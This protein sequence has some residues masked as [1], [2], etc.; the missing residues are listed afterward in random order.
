MGAVK[1]SVACVSLLYA[2]YR[3]WRLVS[4]KS[5]HATSSVQVPDRAFAKRV[6]WITGASSGIGEALALKLA[7]LGAQLVLTARSEEGLDRVAARVVAEGGLAPMVMTASLDLL[8]AH[9]T[10]VQRII[11]RFGALD[12]VILNHGIGYNVP[13]DDIDMDL[14]Q[15][16]FN[17]NVVSKISLAKAC[18]PH[19]RKSK[20]CT[21][22]GRALLAVTASASAYLPSP[23]ASVY[24]ATKHAVKGFFETI[25]VEVHRDIDIVIVAP[26][27]VKSGFQTRHAQY[28]G[29]RPT[30]IEKYR[31]YL[32]VEQVAEM[33]AG[34]VYGG[35]LYVWL[36]THP[37][38]LY[39]YL[40]VYL[41]DLFSWLVPSFSKKNLARNLELYY[42]N[43]NN[44]KN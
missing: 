5:D 14:V 39:I 16:V 29:V 41:P 17:V 7:R 6:L 21:R 12:G 31:S 33:Y 40:R 26:G 9:A 25:R 1:A 35:S 19:L 10:L 43:T 27:P 15:R 3:A 44:N 37:Y 8:D 13:I 20:G 22:N 36:A 2:L 42:Q 30:S 28:T 18:I 34:A 11:E 23:L 4:A 38:L 32:T 24:G